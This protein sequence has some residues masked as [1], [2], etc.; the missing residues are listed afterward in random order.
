MGV[1][2]R[3]S[4]QAG[5]GQGSRVRVDYEDLEF[6]GEDC[7]KKTEAGGHGG[8]ESPVIALTLSC[9]EV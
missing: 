4:A 3:K 5:K 2:K 7:R 1:S 9:A 6:C 8:S